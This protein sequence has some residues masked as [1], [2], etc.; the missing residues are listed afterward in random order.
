M[1]VKTFMSFSSLI[2]VRIL[3]E[4]KVIQERKVEIKNLGVN[5]SFTLFIEGMDPIKKKSISRYY[6]T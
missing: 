6:S 2:F 3:V 5:L 4:K 1:K